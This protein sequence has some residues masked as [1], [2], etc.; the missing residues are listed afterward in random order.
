MIN[1]ALFEPQIPQNTGNIA[2]LAVGLDIPL[3]LVGKLGFS[4]QDR[5]LKRA[6][7][8]YWEFLKLE[9]YQNLKNFQE[10]TENKRKIFVTTKGLIPYFDFQFKK[11]DILLFGSETTGLPVDLLKENLQNTITIPMPGNVRSLNL[12]NSAA[13]VAYFALHQVGYFDGF[14]VNRNFSDLG[15]NDGEFEF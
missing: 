8:D 9:V 6:G 2:R 11:N 5:Y 10:N 4:L 1:I 12:S 7:L 3:M 13:I 14:K 15:V